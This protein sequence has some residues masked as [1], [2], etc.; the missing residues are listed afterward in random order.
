MLTGNILWKLFLEIENQRQRRTQRWV[1][2]LNSTQAC[3]H[4]PTSYASC[5]HFGHWAA[6]FGQFP[7]LHKQALLHHPSIVRGDG[8]RL[9]LDA[10]EIF[11]SAMVI[12]RMRHR[13]RAN[14]GRCT[15]TAMA[16][17]YQLNHLGSSRSALSCTVMV[18]EWCAEPRS[19]TRAA[20]GKKSRPAANWTH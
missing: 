11:R 1:C 19:C 7:V 13:S 9:R 8:G 16:E 14:F 20:Q 18:P 6:R 12:R 15:V 4:S 2:A 5:S 10:S 17:K 3:L